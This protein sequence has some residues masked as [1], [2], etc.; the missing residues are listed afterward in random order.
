M[1]LFV[2]MS[3]LSFVRLSATAVISYKD[4][5]SHFLVF[6]QVLGTGF[7]A[8]TFIKEAIHYTFS[9]SLF[10]TVVSR[11]DLATDLASIHE[12]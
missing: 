11:F 12:N 8:R 2:T 9:S 3:L 7:N 5:Q 10:D 4:Y 1:F 6:L